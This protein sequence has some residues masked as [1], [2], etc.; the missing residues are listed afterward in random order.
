VVT[1]PV[2]GEFDLGE[3]HREA[4][5]WVF[6]MFCNNEYEILWNC[7]AKRKDCAYERE[8]WRTCTEKFEADA[9][10]QLQYNAKVFCPS[11]FNAYADCM[12]G[13]KSGE[14]AEKCQSLWF[15]MQ[16]CAAQQVVDHVNEQK[17]RKD[18][19]FVSPAFV[20]PEIPGRG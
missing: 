10:M 19:K 16:Q 2:A 4:K 8:V 9:Y 1:P 14:A 5:K 6:K 20:T 7:Y 15:D 13:L 12:D 11:Q 17:R 3:T 18:E